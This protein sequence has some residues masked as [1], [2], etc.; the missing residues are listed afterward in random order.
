MRKDR[1]GGPVSLLTVVAVGACGGTAGTHDYSRAIE[2]SIRAGDAHR[3]QQATNGLGGSAT[4]RIDGA[5]CVRRGGTQSYACTV[6][7]TYQNSE[8]I[9]RYDVSVAA[10]CDSGGR[11]RW[12]PDGAGALVGADPSG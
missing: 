4:A 6:H 8:G 5:S 10:R 1:F 7:Y 2:R 11:C 3:V 9:Y 12:H